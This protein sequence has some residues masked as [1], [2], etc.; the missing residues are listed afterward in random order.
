MKL[1]YFFILYQRRRTT[2]RFKIWTN[3]E[4]SPILHRPLPTLR[5][6]G[7]NFYFDSRKLSLPPLLTQSCRTI[8]A[9]CMAIGYSRR[10]NLYEWLFWTTAARRI[11]SDESDGLGYTDSDGWSCS[12]RSL[13]GP[14]EMEWH[15]LSALRCSPLNFICVHCRYGCQYH[16]KRDLV[17]NFVWNN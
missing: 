14:F 9:K 13:R 6:K 1:P 4:R 7:V 17:D 16:F 5:P 10:C 11:D 3:K 12:K 2:R 8:Y 15:N